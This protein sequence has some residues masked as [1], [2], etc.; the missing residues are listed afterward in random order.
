[1]RP[2]G[3]EFGAN[4]ETYSV[5][6]IALTRI[7]SE[8]INY[9]GKSYREPVLI[10]THPELKLDFDTPVRS[11]AVLPP[12]PV[13]GDMFLRFDIPTELFIFNGHSWNK[14]DKNVLNH[15][16]YSHEYIKA[17]IKK[18]GNGEYN[19]ELLNEAEKTHIEELL[20]KK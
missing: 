17:I 10:I 20:G 5:D 1:M 6:N 16:A 9:N 4:N 18:V 2:V 3:K 8:Y 13:L 7:D 14:I 19:P 12:E 11:G 15:S